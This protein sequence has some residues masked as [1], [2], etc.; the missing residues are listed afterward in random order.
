MF[1]LAAA[2]GACLVGIGKSISAASDNSDAEELNNEAEDLVDE[3]R[4][5]VE[6]ARLKSQKE[7]ELLGLE[8]VA[9]WQGPLSRFLTTINKLQYVEMEELGLLNEGRNLSKDT[10]KRMEISYQEV[11]H[12]LGIGAGGLAAGAGAALGAYALVGTFAYASTGTAIVGLSG[13]AATNATLAWLGGGSLAVGGL[14]VTG[15]MCVLGGVVAAPMLLVLGFMSSAKA[16]ENLANAR[17]NLAEAK[18]TEAQA[19]VI[20]DAANG[21]SERLALFWL[22]IEELAVRLNASIDKVEFD[23]QELGVDYRKFTSEA[24]QNLGRA[25]SQA[26][27]LWSLCEVPI[28]DKDG[29]LTVASE[30]ALKELEAP[31]A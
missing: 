25:V 1:L 19:K 21:I 26:H 13:A 27:A 3:A 22:A 15:G 8:K 23:L 4:R 17:S 20:V 28:I 16:K 7:S 5:S 29:K 12:A 18:K 24:K 11:E 9:A 10:I 6:R 14:G 2:I 30:N 31:V